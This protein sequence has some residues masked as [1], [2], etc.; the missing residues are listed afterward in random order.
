MFRV[1]HCIIICFFRISFQM[2]EL[3]HLGNM[4]ENLKTLNPL[5]STKLVEAVVNFGINKSP[6]TL[7]DP[8]VG[9]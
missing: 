6:E 5:N 4:S 8:M 1:H 3:G 2:S 9:K 7:G